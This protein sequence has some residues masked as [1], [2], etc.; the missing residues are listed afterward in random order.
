MDLK[1]SFA[2]VALLAFAAASHAAVDNADPSFIRSDS[3]IR[4]HPDLNW[5][6]CGIDKYQ[7]GHPIEAMRNFHSAARYAD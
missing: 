1:R 6:T 7:H 5:H 2:G 4:A 3:F